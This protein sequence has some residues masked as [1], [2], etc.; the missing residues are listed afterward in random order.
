MAGVAYAGS[1]GEDLGEAFARLLTTPNT[2][3]RKAWLD[4]QAKGG[5]RPAVFAMGRD[6]A[7]CD[8]RRDNMTWGNFR[9]FPRLRDGEV[10]RFCWETV[11]PY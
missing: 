11:N 9:T 3:I 7:D 8:Y 5:N 10:G 1:V 2:S 4:S 6:P